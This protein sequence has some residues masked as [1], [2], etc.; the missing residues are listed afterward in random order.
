MR[1]VVWN[2][3]KLVHAFD[4]DGP[5]PDIQVDPWNDLLNTG[6]LLPARYQRDGIG[7]SI[8]QNVTTITERKKV[9]NG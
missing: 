9:K 4:C 6:D 5:G 2:G 7:G 3:C 8:P 1:V